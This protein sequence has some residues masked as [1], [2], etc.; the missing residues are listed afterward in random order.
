MNSLELINK[1]YKPYKITKKNSVTIIESMD[2]K[3]VVKEKCKKNV[4]DLFSYLYSRNFNYFPN[5][6][7]NSR[8]NVD[9]YEYIED[10]SYPKDQKAIDMIRIVADLHNKT[11]YQKEVRED[12]YKEI[13]DNIKGNLD[14]YKN[15]YT[16]MVDAIEEKVFMS[17]SEY[18]YIRNSSKLMNQIAF[19]ENKLDD[20]YDMVKDNH[21]TRVSIVHNNLA[22][23]HFIRNEKGILVS[24]DKAVIDSPIL[25][26]YNLYK[27]EALNVEF[28]SIL[29]EYFKNS[30]LQEDEK[31]LLLILLCMPP[32]IEFKT[33]EFD[34][35]KS[36]SASLDYVFKTEFLVRPYYTIN[37]KE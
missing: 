1:L 6:I 17:P 36:I 11:S 13:Y 15:K 22:L 16:K 8:S 33:N 18:L 4:K 37:D 35:I 10:V 26:I 30:N 34:S 2:G 7:D 9:I 3:F 23:D 27:K 21:E 25:D 28:G 19:V 32:D 29:K 5:L 14:Y 20:W 31:H 24:W 12:K